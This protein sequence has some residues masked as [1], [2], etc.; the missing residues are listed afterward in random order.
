MKQS[1]GESV[2]R[3]GGIDRLNRAGQRRERFALSVTRRPAAPAV[4]IV[5]RAKPSEMFRRRAEKGQCFYQPYLG[6]REFSADFAWVDATESQP[7]S[8]ADNRDLGWMLYDLEYSGSKPTPCFFRARL[9]NGNLRIPAW[10]SEE[11]VR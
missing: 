5:Q 9:D 1:G 8:I 7:E 11:I 10:D 6:C 4:I 3:A 2:S